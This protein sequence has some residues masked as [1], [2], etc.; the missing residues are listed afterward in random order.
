M[1][2]ELRSIIDED[3]NNDNNA[4]VAYQRST[5]FGATVQSTSSVVI[6][7]RQLQTDLQTQH[8]H[9]K[10]A[11]IELNQRFQLFIDRIQSL[12]SENLKYL[13]TIA[14]IRRQFSGISSTDVQWEESYFTSKSNLSS[15]YHAKVD[16]EW[17]FELFQLQ[18]EIYRQLIEIEQ[19]SKDKRILMLEDELKQSASMLITLRT[20]YEALQRNVENLHVESEDLYKQ[21]LILT[22][23][24]CNVKKQRK[25]WDLSIETLKSYIGFYKNLR[26]YS[27]R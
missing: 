17:D 15:V 9:D 6:N 5:H 7:I 8:Q 27:M 4:T 3:N 19:Q 26:S 23:D 10:D 16:Y 21:Y 13:T 1:S 14:D 11:L 22:H 2:Y 24:W 12:Q 20:S 25:K 18:I